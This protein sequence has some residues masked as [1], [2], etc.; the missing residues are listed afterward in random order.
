MDVY[1]MFSSL[2][3]ISGFL[4]CTHKP[5]H[6]TVLGTVFSLALYGILSYTSD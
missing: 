1:S 6:V 3:E 2:A 5:T 4:L